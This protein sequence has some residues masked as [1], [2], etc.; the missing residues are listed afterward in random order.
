MFCFCLDLP[1]QILKP[2][3]FTDTAHYPLCSWWCKY[4]REK[5]PN[6][7]EGGKGAQSRCK[8]KTKRFSPLSLITVAPDVKGRQDPSAARGFPAE[9]RCRGHAPMGPAAVA[10]QQ[11]RD[12]GKADWWSGLLAGVGLGP[13][14]TRWAWR[15]LQEPT[16]P[17]A[18]PGTSTP[19]VPHRTIS[20]ICPLLTGKPLARILRTLAEPHLQPKVA[21]CLWAPAPVHQ[22]WG[23]GDPRKGQGRAEAPA[24]GLPQGPRG[25]GAP[26]KAPRAPQLCASPPGPRT[27][28]Q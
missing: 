6:S 16:A 15:G 17:P 21:S 12:S 28:P 26:R 14:E 24:L 23:E 22:P 19:S 7:Q 2:A 1:V 9:P 13:P 3:T 11:P 27:G 18:P 4:P 25:V 8:L 5:G 10:A 20:Q